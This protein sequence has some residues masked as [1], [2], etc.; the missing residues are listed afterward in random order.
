MKLLL[1]LLPLIALSV[2][3]RADAK[4][5]ANS[6]TTYEIDMYL[7]VPPETVPEQVRSKLKP[8]EPVL[9]AFTA[10]G[11]TFHADNGKGVGFE[12]TISNDQNNKANVE[13]KDSRYGS[14]GCPNI[15]VVLA[16]NEP[17]VPKV[18]AFSSIIVSYYFRVRNTAAVPFKIAITAE[19]STIVAGGDVLVN[20]SLT[21]ISNQ[22]VEEGVM[23]QDGIGLDSTFRF[24]V[25]DEDGKLVPKRAYPNEEFRTGSIRFH[26]IPVGQTLTQPQPV[27]ALYDMRKPGRYTIQVWRPDTNFDIK[28]NIVTVTITR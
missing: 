22:S 20:V 6:A 26:T 24:E 7:G 12:G 25:R 5:V 23:Y 2:T 18:C 4:Q 14:T 27:S 13:I 10:P 19:K 21:N 8:E 28:S 15:K 11:G 17:I 16:A 9:V 3:F 1:I